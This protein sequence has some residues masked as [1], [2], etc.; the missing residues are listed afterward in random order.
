MEIALR[1]AIA[2]G[3]LGEL[4]RRVRMLEHIHDCQEVLLG[5]E[6]SEALVH[7]KLE[8]QNPGPPPR[9]GA[10]RRDG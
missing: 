4:G 9:G 3:K 8:V 7:T 2:W 5:K 10:Q 1:S 6:I